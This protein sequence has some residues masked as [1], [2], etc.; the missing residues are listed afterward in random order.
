MNK[1]QTIGGSLASVLLLLTLSAMPTLATTWN[2]QVLA[3]LAPANPNAPSAPPLPVRVDDRQNNL[4]WLLILIPVGGLVWAVSRTRRQ[5]PQ[6]EPTP[7]N[8]S[9]LPVTTVDRLL[10]DG[11][12][13]QR[14]RTNAKSIVTRER[15][16]SN[17]AAPE[18]VVLPPPNVLAHAIDG[19]G[20]T[21]ESVVAVDD[22]S[23]PSAL[24]SEMPLSCALEADR[25]LTAQ[26]RLL[27]E[28]LVVD[29]HKRKVGEVIVRKEIE[30]R[31]VRVPIQ[32]EV[33]IV[34]QVDPEFKQLAVVDLGQIDDERT[35]SSPTIAAN[36]TSPTTAIEFLKSL[37]DRSPSAASDVRMNIV[38]EDADDRAFY[39]QWL[40]QRTVNSEW[41]GRV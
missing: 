18:P 40:A 11:R 30:T 6:I 22:R 23:T 2:G 9:S 17:V 34:E 41:E 12:A 21:Q 38:L 14:D 36:F 29:R 10:L 19:N 31:F 37:R 27:E 16:V 32:R 3:Q 24:V 26:I 7:Q 4:W 5:D 33:L 1:F 13:P 35:E 28:R 39:R 15:E 25:Q 20:H 8:T